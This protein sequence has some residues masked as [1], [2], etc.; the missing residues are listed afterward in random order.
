MEL[1]EFTVEEP[2]VNW[3]DQ[4]GWHVAHGPDMAPDTLTAERW[5]YGQVDREG[6]LR[7]A[8][9]GLNRQ[10][11]PRALGDKHRRLV[12]PGAPLLTNCLRVASRGTYD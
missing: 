9:A 7:D 8:M 2:A 4:L 12:H 10:P 6:R 5:D 3:L 1:A 11:P